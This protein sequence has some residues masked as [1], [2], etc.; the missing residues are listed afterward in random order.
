MNRL[1]VKFVNG[2]KKGLIMNKLA[3][4]QSEMYLSNKFVPEQFFLGNI[5]ATGVFIDRF[6][7]IRRRFNVVINGQKTD[8]GFSLDEHFLFDDGERET[9]KWYIKK[10]DNNTYAGNCEDLC[11]EAVGYLC[12][13]R[14]IWQYHFNLK[15]FNRKIRVKFEDVMVQQTPFILLNNAKIKKYVFLLGEV[16][17]SF[18]K[19][20]QLSSSTEK[21]FASNSR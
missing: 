1:R 15:I 7:K 18:N 5:D 14:L 21:I 9:R 17:I 4:N 11:G 8:E 16:F 3:N 13:S 6:G 19:S 10:I 20:H 12:D 2:H